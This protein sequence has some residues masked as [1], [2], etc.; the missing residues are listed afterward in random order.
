MRTHRRTAI[1]V[2]LLVTVSAG[3]LLAQEEN[4]H[5]GRPT[6]E[7]LRPVDGHQEHWPQGW[8][9]LSLGLGRESF[10]YSS[11]PSGYGTQIDAPTFTASAGA[12]LSP[13]LDLGLE[14]YGWFDGE[15]YGTVSIGGLMAIARMHPL[16]R[17]LYLK[18]GGG[19]AMTTLHDAYSCYCSGPTY[20]GFSYGVGAG[21]EIPLG[22]HAAL[23]PQA[24]LFYQSYT[25][26]TFSSYQ[27]RI[28]HVG[29]GISFGFS[30]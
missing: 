6:S 15:R 20:F 27:E 23:E 3:T 28:I 29:L 10:R 30:H 16:G 22:H 13:F 17:F 5:R 24:D 8:L 9:S 25:G 4:G 11:D 18:G 19:F 7:T 12:R 14:G 1:L 2:A 21:L 26:R